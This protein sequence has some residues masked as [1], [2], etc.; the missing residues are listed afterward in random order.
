M[1]LPLKAAGKTVEGQLVGE[2]EGYGALLCCSYMIFRVE[3][4][5]ESLRISFYRCHTASKELGG[6]YRVH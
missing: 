2:R 4:K 3:R 6:G 1:E 5:P